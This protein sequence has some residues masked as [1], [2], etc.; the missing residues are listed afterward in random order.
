MIRRYDVPSGRLLWEADLADS[1]GRGAA[2]RDAL[3]VPDEDYV[4]R[5]DLATGKRQAQ[6]G[7][8]AAS[9]P[10]PMG[11]LYTDGERLIVHGLGR[12]YALTDAGFR[13]Q[14]L[15]RRIA[16]GDIEAQ[17][18]RMR[19]RGQEGDP[20]GA[21][22]DLR[23]AAQAL[24]ADGRVNDAA[25]ALCEG[26]AELGAGEFEPVEIL[27][28]MA[29]TA[30]DDSSSGRADRAAMADQ[31]QGALNAGAGRRR[32][33]KAARDRRRGA[34]CRAFVRRRSASRSRGAGAV[35]RSRAGRR[36]AAAGGRRVERRRRAAAGD[37]RAGER[38]G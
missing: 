12:I 14:L 37:G 1:H 4:V 7:V 17:L 9:S 5:I 26:V 11:N 2:T 29:L 6:A 21:K 34:R 22:D 35:G 23:C 33:A 19:L 31:T 36:G 20:A 8:L 18:E 38:I 10:E 27:R 28:L 30:A 13:L 24:V 3:Y 16:D 32:G 15:A 25:R